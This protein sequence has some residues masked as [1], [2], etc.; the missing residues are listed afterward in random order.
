MKI[1]KIFGVEINLHF[2]A[3]FLFLAAA[4]SYYDGVHLN[5]VLPG[6]LFVTI[7][8]TSVVLHEFAH[9]WAARRC[10]VKCNKIT[11][12]IL[13]AVAHLEDM[14]ESARK[15]LFIAAAGPALSL[16]LFI[17]LAMVVKL[18]NPSKIT[19]P[20]EMALISNLLIGAFN[21]IPAFPLDGGR[22]LRSLLAMTPL[23]FKR[24][25]Q[26]ATFLGQALSV[27][28]VVVGI[29]RVWIMWT[30]FGVLLFFAAGRERKEINN[31]GKT[32]KT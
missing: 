2:T 32:S 7:I 19:N 3:I 22:I 16:L 18:G 26:V 30:V 5:S 23:S 1:A 29:Y 4:L 10:K 15:E 13:G 8:Y 11:I 12:F 14:P 17:L 21:L 20:G 28:F 27:G 6:L 31:H 25:T 9:I 24:A